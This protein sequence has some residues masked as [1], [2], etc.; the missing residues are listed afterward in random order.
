MSNSA[1]DQKIQDVF[2]E[3]AI[4]KG[5]V[6]RLGATGEDRHVPSYVMDWIVTHN[7]KSHQSTG[8]IEHAVRDF[9]AKHLPPKGD[10]ER[11]R[12]CCRRTRRSSC[13]MRSP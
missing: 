4:D 5:L 12:F 6:R 13:W 11:I 1:F 10:K 2:G 3:F 9:I 8:S 7:A